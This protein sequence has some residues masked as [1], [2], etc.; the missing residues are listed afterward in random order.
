MKQISVRLVPKSGLKSY[1]KVRDVL[2]PTWRG[3]I[4]GRLFITWRDK[5]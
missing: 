3:F 2:D 1:G 4:A 5:A